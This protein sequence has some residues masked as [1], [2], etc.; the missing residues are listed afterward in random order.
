MEG[1]VLNEFGLAGGTGGWGGLRSVEK[2]WYAPA[3]WHRQS[4]V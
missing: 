2:Q 3:V 4:S 1:C